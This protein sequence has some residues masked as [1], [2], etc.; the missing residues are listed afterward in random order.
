VRG[1]KRRTKKKPPRAE[2]E[3]IVGKLLWKHQHGGKKVRR[4]PPR[5]ASTRERVL[6]LEGSTLRGAETEVS[7]IAKKGKGRQ[8]G[9]NAKKRNT[10]PA[11]KKWQYSLRKKTQLMIR[12]EITSGNGCRQVKWGPRNG[13]AT[14]H[15]GVTPDNVSVRMYYNIGVF[16]QLIRAGHVA[17]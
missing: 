1:S 11:R 16:L 8:T 17:N 15:P 7:R 3:F 4:S 5:A 2:R 13:S 10:S 12:G 14:K 9:G 6:A